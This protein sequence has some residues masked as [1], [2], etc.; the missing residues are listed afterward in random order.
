MVK[1]LAHKQTK[2]IESDAT[3]KEKRLN[4]GEYGEFQGKIVALPLGVGKS[5]ILEKVGIAAEGE[6]AIKV[7]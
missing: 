2:K 6:Y 7:R 1:Y 3:I 5:V 4:I